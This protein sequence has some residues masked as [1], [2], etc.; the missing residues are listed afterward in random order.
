MKTDVLYARNY[1]AAQ[2]WMDE[3]VNDHTQIHSKSAACE[4]GE[5]PCYDIYDG[6]HEN[7]LTRI[8]IC[9]SCFDTASNHNRV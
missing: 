5:S 1:D 2:N 8:I 4:C 3:Y 6:S 9:E 7:P